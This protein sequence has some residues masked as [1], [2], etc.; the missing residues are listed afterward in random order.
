M[1][2]QYV[3]DVHC[4]FH[5]DNG[6]LWASNIPVEGDVLVCAG[7]IVTHQNLTQVYSILCRRFPFVIAVAGN[8]EYYG[9][10]RGKIHN[11]FQTLESKHDNF[12]F[13]NND[14][15]TV[16]G[17][18]FVG[19][20]LWWRTTDPVAWYALKYL[21]NDFRRIEGYSNW[22][23]GASQKAE[24]FLRETIVPGDIVVTHHAPSTICRQSTPRDMD[25]AY[26]NNLED[27][28]LDQK[29]SHWIFGHTH[30]DTD[31]TLEDTRIVS[32]PMGYTDV[33]DL[34]KYGVIN[35]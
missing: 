17:Q 6:R 8:H 25:V 21:L 28:I 23:E 13:L 5:S 31:I 35:G 30:E 12:K 16:A 26:Y 19:T 15:V 10:N 29:P 2:I 22:I 14:T 27:L 24:E 18:R 7:D 34:N 3:S 20:T 9:S 32:C 1:K 11:K 33:A 4:E